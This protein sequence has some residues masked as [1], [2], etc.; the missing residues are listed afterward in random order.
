[1]RRGL[2]GKYRAL[3]ENQLILRERRLITLRIKK[4]KITS[5]KK[6]QVTYEKRG[7]IGDDKD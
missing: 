7:N 1:M 3:R 5:D 2:N 4:I 6:I